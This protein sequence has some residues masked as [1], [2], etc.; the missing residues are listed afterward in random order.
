MSSFEALALVSNTGKAYM[1]ELLA[2]GLAFK[3]NKFVVGD[4]GHDPTD[5]TLAVTPDAAKSGCYCAQDAMTVSGGCVYEGTI[6]DI[7]YENSTCPVF[8]INL[9]PGQATG[10]ISAICLSATILYSPIPNDPRVGTT[11]VYALTTF[12]LR[13]KIPG[14]SMSW[15]ISIQF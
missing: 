6:S 11:F 14:S 13:V 10:P 1:A 9:E 4:Q 12:P 5:A 2:S 3:V 8:T 15:K 7:S